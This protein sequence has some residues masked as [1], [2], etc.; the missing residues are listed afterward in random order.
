MMTITPAVFWD[1]FRS[2][3]PEIDANTPYQVWYFGNTFRMARQLAGLVLYGEKTATASLKALNDIQPDKAPTDGGYSIVTNFRGRPMCI[4]Q[5]T[6]IRHLPFRNV[7]ADFA[8]DEGEGDRS[9]GYWR[10][11]HRDYFAREASENGFEFDEN[12]IICCERFRLIFPNE[13]QTT[14]SIRRH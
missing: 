6:E 2:L 5:T 1:K 10:D 12:S 11:V 8:F 4:I 9:L 7:D 3:N 14:D 13:L